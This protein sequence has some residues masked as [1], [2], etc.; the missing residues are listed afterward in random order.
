MQCKL[1]IVLA[2]AAHDHAARRGM[3]LTDLIGE[4]LADATGQPYKPQEALPL[5]KSA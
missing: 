1:P 4:L 2:D 5:Q 3:T